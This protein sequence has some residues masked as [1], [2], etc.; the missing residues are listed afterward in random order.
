LRAAFR[1]DARDV[2]ARRGS[3]CRSR[4]RLFDA[5][6]DWRWRNRVDRVRQAEPQVPRRL[7]GDFFDE[8]AGRARTD[9]EGAEQRQPVIGP[10]EDPCTQAQARGGRAEAL[11]FA[12]ATF[13][14]ELHVVEVTGVVLAVER[15]IERPLE[16]GSNDGMIE[17]RS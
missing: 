17:F 5:L 4:R 14:G 8:G 6:N 7:R 13:T 2:G 9:V 11:V 3:G 12:Q 16:E 10:W 15:D 1:D